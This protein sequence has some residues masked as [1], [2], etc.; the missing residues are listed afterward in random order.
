MSPTSYQAALPRDQISKH[1]QRTGGVK[2]NE[3]PRATRNA[4]L[5]AGASNRLT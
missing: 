2:R 3:M 1:T 5:L 4:I